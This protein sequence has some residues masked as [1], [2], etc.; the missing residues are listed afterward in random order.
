MALGLRLIAFGLALGAGAYVLAAPWWGYL[1]GIVVFLI[2]LVT[3][4]M[5]SPADRSGH[6]KTGDGSGDGGG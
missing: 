2:G 3:L 5:D 1:I 6:G 4:S